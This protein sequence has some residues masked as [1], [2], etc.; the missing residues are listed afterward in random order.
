MRKRYMY[1]DDEKDLG[2]TLSGAE[3]VEDV[4]EVNPCR[5]G[6]RR[7]L[8]GQDPV[9]IINGLTKGFRLP[10]WRICWVSGHC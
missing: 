8:M 7:L 2:K 5:P 4:N 6:V 1:P 10:G 3:Y 9:V